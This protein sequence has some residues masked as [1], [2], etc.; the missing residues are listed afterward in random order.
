MK[1]FFSERTWLV[2]VIFLIVG[3]SCFVVSRY[4]N[5]N[6]IHH[7]LLGA[8]TICGFVPVMI[9]TKK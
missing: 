8:G 9:T 5:N 1:A 7:L 6:W 2:M 4:A 3:G